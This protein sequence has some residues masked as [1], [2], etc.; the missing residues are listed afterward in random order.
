VI[1]LD[2]FW[3][4]RSY[5]E[6][7]YGMNWLDTKCHDAFAPGSS[8]EV[9]ILP[10]DSSGNM[11]HMLKSRPPLPKGVT[12][13]HISAADAELHH[14]L[15]LATLDIDDEL[16]LVARGRFHEVQVKRLDPLW[17]FVVIHRD[18]CDW[19]AYLASTRA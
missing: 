4:E 16:K 11:C 18:A 9:M 7:N 12:I 3:L 2:Y 13:E 5:Y 10:A 1:L 6:S 17:P 14:P 19:R 15:V 8:T